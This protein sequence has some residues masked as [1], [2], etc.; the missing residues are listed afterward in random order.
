MYNYYMYLNLSS[1][2]FLLGVGGGVLALISAC[3]LKAEKPVQAIFTSEKGVYDKPALLSL[4]TGKPVLG[5]FK[6][7]K[8][9]SSN[10]ILLSLATDTPVPKILAK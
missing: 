1:G 7:A 3:L 4:A 5:M 2:S 6:S 9:L 8:R 10:P